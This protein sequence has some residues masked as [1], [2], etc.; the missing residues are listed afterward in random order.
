MSRWSSRSKS[1]AP[2]KAAASRRTERL[3]SPGPSFASLHP[4]VR[5]WIATQAPAWT[6]L[7]PI[8]EKVIPEFLKSF[9]G[10]GTGDYIVAA[11]TAAGK[12]EAVFLPLATVMHEA[13]E[14]PEAVGAEILDIC[15]LKALIDQQLGR[16]SGMFDAERFP[17][18]AW[19]KD[20]ND[21]A[22]RRFAEN[23]RGV[24]IITPES[25]E[26]QLINRGQQVA[27]FYGRLRCI[28]I[29]E[30]HAFFD[31]SRG[32]QLV[33]LLARIDRIVGR[34]VP[35]IALSATFNQ[36]VRREIA[37]FLRPAAPTRVQFF[38]DPSGRRLKFRIKAFTQAKSRA[39][40]PVD[41]FAAEIYRDFSTLAAPNKGLIFTDSRKLAEDLAN[42]LHRL[43][44]R[45]D[46]QRIFFP[47]H[48]SLDKV[49]RKNAEDAIRAG[50]GTATLVS[51]PTLE[52]GIDIGSIAQVGQVF[53][54]SRVSSLQQRLGRS[55][56][57]HDAVSSLIAYIE[58]E[59]S[60]AVTEADQSAFLRNLH[61]PTFQMLA[62][63]HLVRAREFEPPDRRPAHLS[64]LIQQVL[65]M[66]AQAGV[67]SPGEL[68]S[69]L[70]KNGP[71]AAL[72]ADTAGHFDLFLKG[73]QAR[74]YL[75]QAGSSPTDLTRGPEAGARMGHFD[76]YAAFP[77][78]ESYTVLGPEGNLGVIPLSGSY[79]VGDRIIFGGGLWMIVA[80]SRDTHTVRVAPASHGEAPRFP[81]D[82]V[83]PSQKV[84]AAMRR[85]YAGEIEPEA[86]EMNAEAKRLFAAGRKHFKSHRLAELGIVTLSAKNFLL[87][88]WQDRR[89]Q[90]SLIAALRYRGLS[91][92]PAGIAVYV[93]NTSELALRAELGAI[94]KAEAEEVH[95]HPS[96]PDGPEAAR[97]VA[98]V[99]LDKHDELLSPYLQRWNYA[100]ARF[101]LK[102]VPAIA[103]ALLT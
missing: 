36:S 34:D 61:M 79:R 60:I 13:A 66:A 72:R 45:S 82:A 35:R 49:L 47:H 28:I 67:V 71:F 94:A 69:V 33:S 8:Q 85:L 27:R 55:G 41:R 80:I 84:I 75:A 31:G 77:T 32:Y 103:E 29:D 42:E 14:D 23:P 59:E 74:N 64:T 1:S 18:T 30:F 24:V 93:E 50:T 22:K 44:G 83:P 9:R 46:A 89:G 12:T 88:P 70:I 57:K 37:E 6:S 63:V 100:T 87:F 81:G 19:H 102:G 53:P 26:A 92:A 40:K 4:V 25:V 16:L 56:R 97:G 86:D 10:A 98:S 91:A 7:R 3:S 58:D 65:S 17:V 73:L 5:T 2:E 101:D 78:P 95:G 52:L 54:P 43:S 20:A 21:A 76:F 38:D 99:I 11:P 15:P 39:V 51:T 90:E 62:Q 48:G 68:S 96:L